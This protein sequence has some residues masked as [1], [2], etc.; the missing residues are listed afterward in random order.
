MITS[1][2]QPGF[3]TFY[4]PIFINI[5]TG[6]TKSQQLV[7][8]FLETQFGFYK[9]STCGEWP[10]KGKEQHNTVFTISW[11]FILGRWLSFRVTLFE[12]VTNVLRRL[13]VSSQVC[14][15]SIQ[16][17]MAEAT[18]S[19]QWIARHRSYPVWNRHHGKQSLTLHSR[20]ARDAPRHHIGA[21]SYN[22]TGLT[23]HW[24]MDKT[25]WV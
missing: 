5:G 10:D 7:R 3:S 16:L 6:K 11:R 1:V 20:L 17:H 2:L 4:L 14:H 24:V 19:L 9:Q 22:K 15:M 12:S 23:G 25:C 13:Y 21:K 18:L 8:R